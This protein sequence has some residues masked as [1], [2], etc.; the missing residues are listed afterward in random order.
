[1]LVAVSINDTE[2]PPQFED[3]TT[4]GCDERDATARRE[5]RIEVDTDSRLMTTYS[6][7]P[8][9]RSA[10]STGGGLDSG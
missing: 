7:Y 4:G 1:M 8:S 5:G 6:S 10:P 3:L 2:L 9:D